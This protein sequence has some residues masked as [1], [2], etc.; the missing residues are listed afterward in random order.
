MQW[1]RGAGRA[2]TSQSCS[3]RARAAIALLL[4]FPIS[5]GGVERKIWGIPWQ[6]A[7]RRAP[8]AEQFSQKVCRGR[9]GWQQNDSADRPNAAAN[10]KVICVHLRGRPKQSYPRKRNFD[11]GQR[12]DAGDI[13]AKRAERIGNTEVRKMTSCR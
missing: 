2:P 6:E 11:T 7:V 12:R 3:A 4:C 9:G 10:C 1:R 5:T 8:L 13:D